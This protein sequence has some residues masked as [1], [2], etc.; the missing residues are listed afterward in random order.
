[1][2]LT[3]RTAVAIS[4]A[5]CRRRC[6]TSRYSKPS[7]SSRCRAKRS[8]VLNSSIDLDSALAI[9]R[10]SSHCLPTSKTLGEEGFLV[11]RFVLVGGQPVGDDVVGVQ[12]RAQHQ[13]RQQQIGLF[14]QPPHLG[15]AGGLGGVFHWPDQTYFVGEILLELRACGEQELKLQQLAQA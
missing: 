7:T 3:R 4:S 9:L 5:N 15:R 1:M 2:V 8:P 10:C 6:A 13:M 14:Q 12:E 11:E